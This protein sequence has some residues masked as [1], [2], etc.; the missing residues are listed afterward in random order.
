M[1]NRLLHF[2][3]SLSHAIALASYLEYENII[4]FGVDLNNSKYFFSD[5]PN[6]HKNTDQAKSKNENHS[7]AK[8]NQL[9]PIDAYI[10]FLSEEMFKN[11]KK[12]YIGTRNNI[13]Y[14]T[15]PHFRDY[16]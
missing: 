12:L 15:L 10:S 9:E 14:L 4:L 6:S 3:G 8:K 13:L 7:T 11:E 1:T 5:Y 16:F 2:R